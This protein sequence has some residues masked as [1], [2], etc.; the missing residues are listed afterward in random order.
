MVLPPGCVLTFRIDILQLDIVTESTMQ[1]PSESNCTQELS[2]AGLRSVCRVQA[3]H[4]LHLY[5][6]LPWLETGHLLK[7]PR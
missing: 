1:A 2:S 5:A 6:C 3:L 7:I 4:M